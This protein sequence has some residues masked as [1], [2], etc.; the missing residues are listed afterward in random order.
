MAQPAVLTAA[1]TVLT[2]ADEVGPERDHCKQLSQPR[3]EQSEIDEVG[4]GLGQEVRTA[5]IPAPGCN[6]EE[7]SQTSQ[8]FSSKGIEVIN[9]GEEG[10]G[11][12]A[13]GRRS[14]G[15]EKGWDMLGHLALTTEPDSG[16]A[17]AAA[18]VQFFPEW[19]P[20]CWGL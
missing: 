6:S 9:R 20:D 3:A 1:A 4:P 13:E 15:R 2:A 5:Q 10:L 7:L 14:K 11:E 16:E 12:T 18:A 17:A 8:P 19:D